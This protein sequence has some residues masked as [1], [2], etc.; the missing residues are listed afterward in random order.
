MNSDQTGRAK[1]IIVIISSMLFIILIGAYLFSQPDNIIDDNAEEKISNECHNECSF[2]GEKGCF[3]DNSYQICSID[4]KDCLI[5]SPNLLCSYGE[6]CVS[7][8]CIKLSSEDVDESTIDIQC[9]SGL[10]CDIN[11]KFLSETNIC[12]NIVSQEYECDLI[13]S[14][15]LERHQSKFCSGDSS[16]CS[17]KVAWSEWSNYRACSVSE[18]CLNGECV[19]STCSDG[20]EYNSCSDS[21]LKYCDSGNLID[22][23][24]LCGCLLGF[25]LINGVCSKIDRETVLLVIDEYFYNDL[26]IKS[27]IDRYKNSNPDYAFQEILFNKTN[28]KIQSMSD[29]GGTI[30]SNS[31]ELKNT[32]KDLYYDIN[33]N[34]VG[35]WIIG[36]IRPTVWRE[37]QQWM[38]LGTSGFYP[39]IYPLISFD[40]EYYV[41]F[42]VENDGFYEKNGVTTGCEIGGG[43]ESTIWGAILIPPTKDKTKG[44]ELIE[45]YFDKNHAYRS[46]ILDFNREVLY[47]SADG[48]S[49]N[50]YSIVNGSQLWE[51]DD[52]TFLCPNFHDDLM[53]FN[54]VYEIKIGDG[55]G[56]QAETE[57]EIDE[58]GEWMSGDYFGN[59]K[60]IESSGMMF[61][62]RYSFFLYL[63]GRS[64]SIKEI[65]T[66]IKNN[67]PELICQRIDNCD[68]VVKEFAFAEDDDT[69]NGYWSS[70]PEQKQEWKNLYTDL[71]FHNSFEVTYLH[72]HGASTYHDFN[73]DFTDVKSGNYKSMIY[74]LQ[75]C[76]TA[77]YNEENYIAGT[78]LFYGD[79]LAVSAYSIPILNQGINGY[80][81]TDDSIR[82]TSITKGKPII[83]SLFLYNYG[84]YLYLGD[85]L[86]EF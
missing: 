35:I 61:P 43:H 67:L 8:S 4:S 84:N 63:E 29:K 86:L 21:K 71:L 2:L 25:E 56:V 78:Y 3:N 38:S 59:S 65:E 34:L 73:L 53:G 15:I 80:F 66:V 81:E 20:T 69:W 22:N 7:G 39:S 37:A 31:L 30:K 16:D 49:S 41:D 32:I 11:N 9:N 54:S 60:I 46:G 28:D 45:D 55:I 77:N 44:K 42:D 76:N 74:E 36:D 64:L 1:L 26:N 48:C 27:K 14:K 10:C 17:G 19:K 62:F 18:K 40:D 75:S 82:F 68:I 83:E 12:Q 70:Y 79:T 13:N 57:E 23:P 47:S 51:Q 52:V 85:P 50:I 33:K 58:Y 6:Q 72:H 24:S 5:W